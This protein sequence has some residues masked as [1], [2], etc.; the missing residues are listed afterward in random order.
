M[1][2]TSKTREDIIPQASETKPQEYTCGLDE[3]LD[4]IKEGRIYHA[5]SAEDMMKQIF[6]NNWNK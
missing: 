2:A 6:G 3:A 5:A 4:D 1:E